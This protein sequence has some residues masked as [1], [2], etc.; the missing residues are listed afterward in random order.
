MHSQATPMDLWKGGLE[1]GFLMFETQLVMT[2][3][4][5]GMAGLWSVTKLEN[6]RMV[7][8]KGPAFLEAS[9]SATRAVMEGRRPDEV[10]GAWVRP[11][12]LKTRKNARRLGRRGPRRL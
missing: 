1:I 2:Y 12:R 11:L 8:E 3:R 7:D 10:L 4:L 6:R 5:M 9:V